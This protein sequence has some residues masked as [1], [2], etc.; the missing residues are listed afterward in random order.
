M[1]YDITGGTRPGG[2]ENLFHSFGDFN[3]PSNNIANFLNA[4]SVDM[5]GNPLA[6]G[7]P[8]TNILGRVTGVDP[9]IIFGMIQTN[10][11]GGF[12]NANLFL[13]NP[14]GFLFG[15]NATVNVGGMVAF[16]TADYL[17]LQ[18]IGGNGIFYA[19]SAATSIIT[20][21]PVAAFGFLGSNPSA[22]AIQGSTLTVAQGHSL[23]LVGGNKGF[24]ATDPDTGNR[25]SIPDGVTMTA[26][27]LSARGGQINLASVGGPGEIS[28][29]DFMPSAGMTMGKISLSQRALLDVSAD[30][31]GTI[32]IRG[33]QFVMTDATL[34]AN[35][36]NVNGAANAIDI[37]VTGDMS[38]TDTRA[39][40]AI[41][42]RT[43]GAG[44]AGEVR[45]N[46]TNLK[47]AS[48]AESLFSPI[49]TH[50]ALIDTHTSGSGKAGSVSIKTIDNLN[51]IG[52][53]TGPLFFID[54]GTIGMD[55]GH[56]GAVTMSAESIQLENANINSGDNVAVN[57]LQ[58]AAGS[59]GNVTITTESL[60]MT[61]S[62]IATT[63]FFA[64]R[65]GDLTINAGDIDMNTFSG[66]ALL[67]F[68]GGGKLT[69]T[70]DRSVADSVQFD[71]E[72][73]SGQGGGLHHHGQCSGTEKWDDASESDR[74]RR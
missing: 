42:A 60:S 69:I 3:V 40:P 49:D 70:A 48:S 61:R 15:P 66:L 2:G 20:S 73:V 39:V 37:N 17:R 30:A 13:M 26:G 19:H 18:G 22:I 33:G 10:G 28:A 52:L 62:V 5:A 16:T 57:T 43:T 1:Q 46:S 23:S 68:Q 54:S 12:G 7:L 32:S 51:V 4:G 9:S 67:E 53:P 64:G 71:A 47:A 24:T 65:A 41:T 31:A 29:V 74:R 21:A 25:I 50:F 55:G 72:N 59:G 45:I 58:D 63:G 35:T 27:K 14:H 8:T 11:T 6:A 34:S 44:D 56:G 38:I 36:A